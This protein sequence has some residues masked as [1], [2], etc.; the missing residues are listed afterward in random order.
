M[1]PPQP[2]MPG[3]V[4]GR[5]T[6]SRTW[7]P[8]AG[9]GCGTLLLLFVLLAVIGAIAGPPDEQTSPAAAT[10]TS[11]APASTTPQ[12][13]APPAASPSAP[14]PSPTASRTAPHPTNEQR[15]VYLARVR[16]IDPALAAKPERDIRR[17]R[18]ICARII[19]PPGGTISLTDYTIYM[20]SGPD[21]RLTEQQAREVIAA[22]K[23]WC[24]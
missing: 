19:N 16:L 4:P 6:P 17:A 21:V 13:A 7:L 20:L 14:A 2:P 5:R 12:Q 1:Q 10:P 11:P 22:V 3:Q 15:Q 24:R 8:I 23:A 18:G 9:I